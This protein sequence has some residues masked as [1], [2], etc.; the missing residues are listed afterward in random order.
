MAQQVVKPFT[1]I[2][3]QVELLRAR[4]MMLDRDE[5][6]RWLTVV[7]YY[8]LSGYWYPYRALNTGVRGDQFVQDARFDDVVRLYEFD[9]K[10]RTQ[11]HDGVERIEVALRSR[12]SYR[13]AEHDPL[14]YENPSLFRPA[15]EHSEWL[16][17]ARRRVDRAKRHIE[18]I[19]HY[20]KKYGGRVPIWVLT[21]VLDFSDVSKLYDGMLVRDQWTVAERLG[22]RVDEARLTASQRKKGRKVHP[23]ARWL[24]HLTV[25]RNSAAHHGRV[26]NRSFTPV[27]TAGLR[28]IDALECLPEGQSER[29]FGA[30]T[31]M[32]YLLQGT[33]PGSSWTS[34]VRNLVEDTFQDL[35]GRSVGEMGF[36]EGW[37]AT[38]LW[39]Q[40]RFAR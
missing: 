25:I 39:S 36:P 20:E 37:Q 24:E 5:A 22:V 17:T 2:G 1:T 13:I 8:R 31:L 6:E 23:L 30:L 18:P 4:G 3:K 27:G 40:G 14:G 21:E 34:K 26:W 16:A 15:F 32:G 29:A 12:V 35:P 19:R 9:R 7:G 11:I 10:L 28:T 33:S 38:P